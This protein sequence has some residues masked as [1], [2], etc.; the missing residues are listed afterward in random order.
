MFGGFPTTETKK[1]NTGFLRLLFT[2][3][4]GTWL[5]VHQLGAPATSARLGSSEEKKT[6]TANSILITC[7]QF[8]YTTT[9]TVVAAKYKNQGSEILPYVQ[10]NNLVCHKFM[11]AGTRQETPG[12]E[13]QDVYFPGCMKQYEFLCVSSPFPASPKGAELRAQ[14]D[15]VNET[16]LCHS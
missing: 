2:T 13:T 7:V 8:L 5:R 1:T 3:D 4:M 9:G 12:S 15:T 6:E 11:D 10:A 14:A 16:S